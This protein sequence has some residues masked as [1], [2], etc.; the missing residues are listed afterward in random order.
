MDDESKSPYFS[1]RIRIADV[2][3]PKDLVGYKEFTLELIFGNQDSII[4]K[5]RQD[6]ADIT[7]KKIFDIADEI[8]DERDVWA[9]KKGFRFVDSLKPKENPFKD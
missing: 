1:K 9:K 3:S 6:V 8:F 2:T 7:E 4:I 5:N